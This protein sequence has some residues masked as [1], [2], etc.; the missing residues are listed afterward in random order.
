MFPWKYKLKTLD[1]CSTQR[2]RESYKYKQIS[3]Y[4]IFFNQKVSLCLCF[5]LLK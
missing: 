5:S 4:G 1:M 2:H 3:H